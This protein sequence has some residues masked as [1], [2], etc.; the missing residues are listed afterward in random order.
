MLSHIYVYSKLPHTELAY[1][2][3]KDFLQRNPIEQFQ[4]PYMKMVTPEP[5]TAVP[6]SY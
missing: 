2:T 3:L 5:F 4:N 1:T 6:D